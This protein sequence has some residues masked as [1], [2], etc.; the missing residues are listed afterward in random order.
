M[1]NV[2]DSFSGEYDFL[3]NF[4]EDCKIHI[5]GHWYRGVERAYQAVKT[6]SDAWREAI[7]VAPTS[8]AAKK[9][10]RKL[11]LRPD[12]NNVKYGYMFYFVAQKF[13]LHPELGA[14]LIATGDAE[15]IEGNWWGDVYWGVCKGKGE[16]NLGKI[17]M[18]I[19]QFLKDQKNV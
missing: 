19:R 16:N 2:I 10:G 5:D 11:V 6:E 9:L 15:L 12:W 3:S 18:T 13:I 1:P 8:G 17:L 7:R 4:Y 14:K